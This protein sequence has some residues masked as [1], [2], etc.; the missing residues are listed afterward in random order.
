MKMKIIE[1]KK[2]I[3]NDFA[4]TLIARNSLSFSFIASVAVS[5]QLISLE[6]NIVPYIVTWFFVFILP[7]LNIYRTIKYIKYIDEKQDE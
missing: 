2:H 1:R 4:S 3:D 7:N 6:A 5:F